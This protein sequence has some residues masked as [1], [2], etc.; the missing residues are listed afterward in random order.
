M[1]LLGLPCDYLRSRLMTLI[2]SE[3]LDKWEVKMA[4][5]GSFAGSGHMVRNKLC[6]DANDL[7]GLPKQRNSHQS[8]PTFL[9]FE[10]PTASQHNSLCNMWPEHVKGPLAKI[11]LACS[12]TE[13][14][15]K[16][17]NRQKRRR[18]ISSHLDHKQA[19]P[20]KDLTYDRNELFSGNICSRKELFSGIIC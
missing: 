20:I 17:L 2:T 15:S 5:Y 18:I 6:Q 13:T 10:S 12:W 11:F 16:F 7:V 1:P 4:G 8:S 3:L 19:W 9:Y 14:T